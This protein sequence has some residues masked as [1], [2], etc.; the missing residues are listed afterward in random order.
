M[1]YDNVGL[2]PGNPH[3]LA[4]VYE[5]AEVIVLEDGESVEL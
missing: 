2:F 1:H 4:K 3:G 5:Q